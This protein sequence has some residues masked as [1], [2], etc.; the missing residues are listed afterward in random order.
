[1]AF[2]A[3][4]KEAIDIGGELIELVNTFSAGA[5]QKLSESIPDA[6]TDLLVAFNLDI[7]QAKVIYLAADQDV[8]VKTN[9]SS[10]PDDTKNLLAGIPLVWHASSDHANPFNADITALYVTNASG[11]AAALRFYDLHDPTV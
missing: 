2:S 9:S 8:T 1:M 7:T 4:I 3:T 10:V 6:S 5:L 11:A